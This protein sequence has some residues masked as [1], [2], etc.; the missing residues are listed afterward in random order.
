MRL[1]DYTLDPGSGLMTPAATGVPAGYLDGAERYL[2]D[3]LGEVDDR[4]FGSGELGRHVRDWPSHYHLTPY[5]ATLFD[6]LGFHGDGLRA[7]EL[8]AGC[9]AVT[10]WLGEHLAEVH[11]VEG[12]AERARVARRRCLDLDNVHVYVG[13]YSELEESE[14][15]DVATLIGVLEYGHLYHPVHGED[16][17]AAALD[18]LRI[19]RGSLRQHGALVLAIEN[20]LGLKYF[21]GAR[22]DHSGQRFDSI[23]GYPGKEHPVTFSARELDGLLEAA[24]FAAADWYLPF[25]DYKLAST[26]LN[27]QQARDE[28][29]LHNWIPAPAPDR[30]AQRDTFLFR[31]SLA[32]REVTGAGLLRDLANS[33]L[34]VA[35]AGDPAAA[36]ERLGLETDWVARHYALDRAPALRKRV[37]LHERAGT[38]VVEQEDALGATGEPRRCG[39][40]R[41]HLR[42]EPFRQGDLLLARVIET[43]ACRGV[44]AAFITHLDE[45][46]R[47]LTARYGGRGRDA[48]GAELLSGRA[49]DGTWWNVVVDGQERWEPIDE[50][51]E[52]DG[53]IPLDF[54]LWRTLYHFAERYRPYLPQPWSGASSREFA[55]AHLARL[56][57]EIDPDRMAWMQQLEEGLGALV[58]GDDSRNALVELAEAPRP[59]SLLAF[60]DEVIEEPALLRAYAAQF[61][62]ADPA[63]LVLWAPGGDA[64][65][66]VGRM[67]AA[68]AA[69]GLEADGVPDLLLLPTPSDDESVEA[70]AAG[71]VALLSDRPPPE[72]LAS[73]PRFGAEGVA[74]LR[75]LVRERCA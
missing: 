70:I 63:T 64:G 32:W 21:A 48:S 66:L 51:W 43:V 69:A 54:V 75:T 1:R 44:G 38:P 33:F 9:G 30:G 3:V 50:E 24:G 5:R 14:A 57:P 23:E 47:W 12:S 61:D 22:E 42:S 18:N 56:R 58:R 29:R 2:H 59:I 53:L 60:A 20:K 41:Q 4:S 25:P 28:H 6:C 27:V 35:Y 49:V 17:H 11:A 13:N 40:L 67:E 26:I 45:L 71:S 10:R 52:L 7:L 36:K 39:P 19:V 8:G 62:P 15:F 16:P 34:V 65:T 68:I 46:G 74:G 37:T 73:L 72:A 31:E 55:A